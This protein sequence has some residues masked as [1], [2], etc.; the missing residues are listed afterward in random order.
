MASGRR[1]TKSKVDKLPAGGILWD[2]DVRGF[3]VRKQR[4]DAVYVLKYRSSG[5]QRL[6]TIGLHGS[7]WTVEKARTEAQ[8]LLGEIAKGVDPAL[9][10]EKMKVAPT[11]AQF[12]ERYL[13]EVSN[14]HKKAT[15]ARQDRRTLDRHILPCLGL[16]K[17]TE[18]DRG[19]VARLHAGMNA[20]PIMANR[21]IALLSHM[22]TYATEKGERPDGPNPCRRVKKYAEHARE[23]FLSGEELGRLGAAIAEAETVGVPWQPDPSKNVKHAPK[24]ENRRVQI[25]TYAAAALRLLLLTGGRLR[26][27]LHLKWDYVDFDRGVLFLPDSKTGKK[28]IVLN[29]PALAVLN[30][31]ERVGTYVIAGERLEKPRADLKRPWTLVRRR[32]GLEGLRLHDLRHT[33]ASFGVGGGLG[34]PIIGKLLGHAQAS[35]TARYAHLDTDPVRRASDAIA[36]RIAAAMNGQGGDVVLLR[37][38]PMAGA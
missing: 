4:R 12:A 16:R 36:G 10:R 38:P 13:L 1:I 7:P 14:P 26:E 25:D 35:T 30:G 8:R 18:I 11:L 31:L 21:T 29:A 9:L 34:L 19:D 27:I 3:A 32:A 22:L 20:T 33:Y 24:E 6:Y 5:K 2:S 28:A 17:V 37:R 15:T 23:R